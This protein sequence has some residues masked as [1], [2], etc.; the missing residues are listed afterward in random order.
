M[1]HFNT[2]MNFSVLI[3]E[4]SGV[5]DCNNSPSVLFPI[6]LS[7]AIFNYLFCLFVCFFK[8]ITLYR[9]CL[10]NFYVAHSIFIS[11]VT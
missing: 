6:Y 2:N 11:A 5:E 10:Q 9:S 8:C 3:E 1:K 4:T 7:I